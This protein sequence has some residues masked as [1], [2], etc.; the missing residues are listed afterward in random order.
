MYRLPRVPMIQTDMP[1]EF[2]RL[3]FLVWHAVIITNDTN[4][5]SI[6]KSVCGSCIGKP[7]DLFVY[8]PDGKINK[9]CVSK[10][11]SIIRMNTKR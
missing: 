4:T 5:G 8:A 10:S 6:A 3:Q 2:K 11:T 7:Y 9:Y 1:F